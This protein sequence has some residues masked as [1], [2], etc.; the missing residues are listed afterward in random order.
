MLELRAQ[1]RCPHVRCVDHKIGHILRLRELLA[2]ALDSM[3]EALPLEGQ[4]MPSSVLLVAA[5]QHLVRCL[6]K[7]HLVR[8]LMGRK[9]RQR[10]RE[11][12]EETLAPKVARD[13]KMSSDARV[14]ADKLGKLEDE[15]RRQVVEAVV[16]HILEGMEG[17]C[18]PRSAHARDDHDVRHTCCRFGRTHL[19]PCLVHALVLPSG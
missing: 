19:L 7:D 5:D 13:R 1:H 17:L 6:E 18:A 8:E 11:L 15:A 2:L 14:D 10:I 3:L 12:L 9:L 16:A 4:R